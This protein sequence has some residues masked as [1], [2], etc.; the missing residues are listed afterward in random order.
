MNER[1]EMIDGLTDTERSGEKAF[2]GGGDYGPVVLYQGQS[3]TLVGFGLFVGIGTLLAVLHAIFYLGAYQ[4]MPQDNQ[5]AQ[6]AITVAIVAPISGYIMTRLLDIRTWLSGEKSFIEYIRTVSFGLW[7]SL[8]GGLIVIT[9]FAS[10][11]NIAL[12][13]L[14]DAFALGVPLAQAFGRLGC[15]NYGC[16]H[17]KECTSHHQPGIRYFDSKTK[18][19]RFNP[20]LRGKRLHPTQLYSVLANTVIYLTILTLSIFWDERPVGMLIAM[21]MGMYGIKRF[22]VE[23]LRGEFPRVYFSGLTIW[24]WF[25]VSFIVL[26]LGIMTYVLS[27]GMIIGKYSVSEGIQSLRATLGVLILAPVIMGLAYGTHGRKIGSW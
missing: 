1:V 10:I 13:A 14:L 18:V 25:S 8:T 2:S 3:F 4:I 7:G 20:E 17:G 9:A 26:G 6:L 5:I 21:Y 23:F 27:G 22:N 15:L 11:N 16:C 24:Q 19:L 12:L